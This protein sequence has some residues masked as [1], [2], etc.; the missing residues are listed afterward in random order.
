MLF[1]DTDCTQYENTWI[2]KSVHQIDQ[3]W[4][5]GDENSVDRELRVIAIDRRQTRL[6]RSSISPFHGHLKSPFAKSPLVLKSPT[7]WFYMLN[8]TRKCWF[9]L[10]M[11]I[12]PPWQSTLRRNF[13]FVL[14][15]CSILKS[16]RFVSKSLRF[17]PK[18]HRKRRFWYQNRRF[19]HEMCKN[20]EISKSA[21]EIDE[22]CSPGDETSVIRMAEGQ[23]GSWDSQFSNDAGLV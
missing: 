10:E 2:S 14:L 9:L 11:T 3:Y 6:K 21:R 17:G 23:W 12:L 15:G 7:L 20:P 13:R 8:S 4:S 22:H 16:L 18:S 19:R 1:D 5:P